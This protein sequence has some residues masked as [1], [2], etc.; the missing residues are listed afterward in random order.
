VCARQVACHSRKRVDESAIGLLRT[1]QRT[2][3]YRTCSDSMCHRAGGHVPT[4]LRRDNELTC[5]TG[6]L[7]QRMSLHTKQLGGRRADACQCFAVQCAA[8]RQ[9]AVGFAASARRPLPTF[10]PAFREKV[11]I[12][13][14]E[15][16][17]L[18]GR[19]TTDDPATTA[20]TQQPTNLGNTRNPRATPTTHRADSLLAHLHLPLP[21][22]HQARSTTQEDTLRV[23]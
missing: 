17:V 15:I 21:L 7:G 13:I 10:F 12:E 18:E 23:S 1:N 4:N 16:I 8:K 20:T 3:T 6:A 19:P 2:C 22:L 9:R 14:S 5:K 11:R